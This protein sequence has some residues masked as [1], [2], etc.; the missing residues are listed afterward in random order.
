MPGCEGVWT[1][2]RGILWESGTTSVLRTAAHVWVQS[3]QG[4]KG[5]VPR[6]S[7][8][9]LDQ[10][11]GE[12]R[13][14]R[15]WVP[16]QLEHQDIHLARGPRAGL[17]PVEVGCTGS[18]TQGGPSGPL[19]LPVPDEEE[20]GCGV[21]QN[22]RISLSGLK[23]P[24]LELLAGKRRKWETGWAGPGVVPTHTP[25]GNGEVGGQNR[26]FSASGMGPSRVLVSPR[27]CFLPI[28][29]T[30]SSRVVCA[31]LWGSM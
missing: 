2:E 14:L 6:I 23:L 5:L 26:P 31:G 13:L 20:G 16:P 29:P 28:L 18:R 27:S 8:G 3:E 25:V 12:Q 15:P 22:C 21:G 30:D 24:D 1:L 19:T 7:S 10:L 4:T 9:G 11:Q 17:Q